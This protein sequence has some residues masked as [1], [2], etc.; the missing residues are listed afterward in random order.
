MSILRCQ[1]CD[2][3]EEKTISFEPDGAAI[4]SLTVR[5]VGDR[6]VAVRVF[7]GEQV[8]LDLFLTNPQHHFPF[9]I[10]FIADRVKLVCTDSSGCPFA[11]L[12]IA[13]Q[14]LASP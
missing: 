3:D 4:G 11:D 14:P 7:R 13:A 12:S 1:F 9:P 10:P 6:D 5:S 8:I 2:E